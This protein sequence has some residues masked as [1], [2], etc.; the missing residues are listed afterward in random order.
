MTKP[1]VAVVAFIWLTVSGLALACSTTPIESEGFADMAQTNTDRNLLVDFGSNPEAPP[2]PDVGIAITLIPAA[3]QSR[4]P[5]QAPIVL[6]GSFQADGTLL[7]A[8]SGNPTTNIVLVLRR[9]DTPSL[10]K[11]PLYSPKTVFPTPN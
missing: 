4:Y 7:G 11:V 8:V 9:T 1:A 6:A 3:A 10:I 2:P 5:L